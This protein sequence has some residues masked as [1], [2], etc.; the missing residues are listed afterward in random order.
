MAFNGISAKVGGVCTKSNKI[1]QKNENKYKELKAALCRA[2]K[3]VIL[4]KDYSNLFVFAIFCIRL[5]V[6]ILNRFLLVFHIVVGF[7]WAKSFFTKF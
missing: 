1:S 4:Y 6:E 5:F 7:L 3:K 2:E